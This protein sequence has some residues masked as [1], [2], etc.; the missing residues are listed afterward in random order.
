[1]D[2]FDFAPDPEEKPKRSFGDV[3]FRLGAY[4]FIAASLCLVG[5]FVM[6][7]L[8][9]QSSLNPFPPAQQA[10]QADAAP[11]ATHTPAPTESTAG[12]TIFPSPTFTATLELPTNTPTITA[13]IPPYPTA[14]DVILNT[15]T[16]APT[17]SVIAHFKAQEGTPT[18]LPY[19]GGCSGLYIAGNVVDINSQPLA[20]VIVRVTGTLGDEQISEEA[21]SGSNTQY[22]ESGWEIKIS[23]TLQFSNQTISVALYEQ[24]GFDPIS[25]VIWI[26]TYNSCSENLVVVNFVQDE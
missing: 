13:T 18:Y 3:I 2:A 10:A 21:L 12:E 16:P 5:Y 9:P 24:G 1:M 15:N 20:F 11:T 25:D 6:I 4:Y 8:N 23:D 26:D 22:T 14:T 19:S 7:Y 17:T